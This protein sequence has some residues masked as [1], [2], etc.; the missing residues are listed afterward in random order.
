MSRGPHH[1]RRTAVHFSREQI[2]TLREIRRQPAETADGLEQPPPAVMDRARV[3]RELLDEARARGLTLDLRGGELHLTVL[4]LF[5]K[6]DALNWL[7]DALDHWQP[8]IEQA[9]A[10]QRERAAAARA[11]RAAHHGRTVRRRRG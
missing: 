1:V 4:G 3:H 7:C 6:Q 2:A 5:G 11:E 9:E 10:D 8:L